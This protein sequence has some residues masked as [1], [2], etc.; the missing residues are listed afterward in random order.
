MLIV[1]PL[2]P[3]VHA[4]MRLSSSSGRKGSGGREREGWCGLGVLWVGCFGGRG[5]C[6]GCA[7]ASLSLP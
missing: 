3:Q 1:N 6:R 7:G 5:G 2:Q 4:G